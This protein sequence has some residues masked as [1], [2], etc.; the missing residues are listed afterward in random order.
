MIRTSVEAET[1]DAPATVKT[2]QSISQVEQALRAY[3]TMDLK[4]R[5]IYHHLENR[6]IVHVF[7][8]MLYYYVEWHM[9]PA[10]APILFADEESDQVKLTPTEFVAPSQRSKKALSKARKKKTQD[11]FPV[12]SFNTLMADLGTITLNTINTKLEGT[13]ITFEKITQATLLQQKALD[14]LGVSVF[15]TQ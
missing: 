6:V 3:K 2:Y 10:L 4:V 13:D 8:C 9:K 1:L 7:L 14:L 11:K 5:P 15:C 12:H